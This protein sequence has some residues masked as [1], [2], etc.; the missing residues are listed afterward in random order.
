MIPVQQLIQL[1]ADHWG[2]IVIVLS[3]VID[4]TPKIKWNPWKSFFG[5]VGD[6][7]TKE[8][9]SEISGFKTEVRNEISGLKLDVA[10]VAAEQKRQKEE[11][12]ENEMDRIRSEVLDF[13]N[14]CRLNRRHTKEEFDH[15]FALNDKYS[16]LLEQTGQQNGRFEEAYDYIRILYR[17]CMEQNDFL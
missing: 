13:A 3:F 1:A 16:H 2:L 15:I 17:R 8:V 9:R 11:A 10:S 6:L 5:W 12:D 14:S 4:W 7:L